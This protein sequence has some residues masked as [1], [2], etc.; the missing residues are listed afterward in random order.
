MKRFQTISI[1][2]PRSLSN[3]NEEFTQTLLRSHQ[4]CIIC[5]RP[6]LEYIDNIRMKFVEGC[7]ISNCIVVD[8]LEMAHGLYQSIVY[9]NSIGNTFPIIYLDV[10]TESQPI[11]NLQKS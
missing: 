4:V 9:Q 7:G 11:D 3:P 10:L 6:T 1:M 5:P 2:G 8:P